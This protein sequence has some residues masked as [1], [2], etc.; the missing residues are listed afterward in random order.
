MGQPL[1]LRLGPRAQGDFLFLYIWPPS[2][3]PGPGQGFCLVEFCELFGL[4]LVIRA[5]G[6]TLYQG[7]AGYYSLPLGSSVVATVTLPSCWEC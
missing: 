7:G 6:D 4:A 1:A 2:P 5:E 3:H